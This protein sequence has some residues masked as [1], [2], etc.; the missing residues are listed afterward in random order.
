MKYIESLTDFFKQPNYVKNIALAGICLLIPIVGPMVVMGWLAIGFWGRDD[1]N[2]ATFPD[3]DFGKFSVYLQRGL[4]P[5][6]VM[7]AVGFGV[8][9]VLFVAMA[10]VGSILSVIGGDSGILAGLFGLVTMLINL[11]MWVVILLVIKPLKIRSVL[12]QDFAK[13][14]DVPFVK[15][16][17]AKV[18]KEGLLS[19]LF[20]MVVSMVLMPLGMLA[21]C[22][23]MYFAMAIVFYATEH[24]DKQLYDL[25]LTRG[26][27]PVEVSPLLTGAAEIVP[28]PPAPPL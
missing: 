21:L 25:Y 27:T 6:L 16:F 5:F 19:A 8:W 17:I 18:W 2:P 9:I 10:I 12:A 20:I 7:L 3:F 23:G 13:S 11:A 24:L 4:W 26:G 22:I 14:F 1:K 28:P 15:L